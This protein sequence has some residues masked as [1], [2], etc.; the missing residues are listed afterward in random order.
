M[1]AGCGSDVISHWTIARAFSRLGFCEID[2]NRREQ[3]IAA[4]QP[5]I[6]LLPVSDHFC[7]FL[8]GGRLPD[9]VAKMKK[10]IEDNGDEVELEQTTDGSFTQPAR[11]VVHSSSIKSLSSLAEASGLWHTS[12]PSAWQLLH[13]A[14]AARTSTSCQSANS[15]D[16][17][18]NWKAREYCR[19]RL[20][21]RGGLGEKNQIRLIEFSEPNSARRRYRFIDGESW[22]EVESSE[23]VRLFL[24]RVGVQAVRYAPDTETISVAPLALPPLYERALALCSGTLPVRA[25]IGTHWYFEYCGVPRVIAELLY[26]KLELITTTSTSMSK[27]RG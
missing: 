17:I 19:L 4:A 16:P 24:R 9:T 11:I 26:A 2:F 6:A 20:G 18:L 8:T 25:R 3:V 15:G 23:G 13:W 1:Q 27:T 14:P 21:F 10:W 12:T 22:Y 5:S 7:G